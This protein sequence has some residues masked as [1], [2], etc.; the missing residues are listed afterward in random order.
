M[1]DERF[2]NKHCH[3]ANNCFSSRFRRLKAQ[4][5]SLQLHLSKALLKDV[6]AKVLFT[7]GLQVMADDVKIIASK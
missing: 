3:L 7:S 2:E 5:H 1:M 4:A 6:M